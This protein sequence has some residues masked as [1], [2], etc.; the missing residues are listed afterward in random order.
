MPRRT[1]QHGVGVLVMYVVVAVA[2]SMWAPGQMRPVFD[3][4]GSHPGDYHWVNPPKEF[5]EGNQVPDGGE[6]GVAFDPEGSRDA[7]ASTQD[8]QALATIQRGSVPPHPPD[9]S[10]V[11]KLRPL[12]SSEFGPLPEGL[13]AESNVYE[14]TVEY[15]P[16]RRRTTAFTKPG[17]V[18]LTSAGPADVLLYSPDGKRW[19]REEASPITE[20]DGVTGVATGPGYY[21]AASRGDPRS[22]ATTRVPTGLYVALAVVPLAL[23]L[24]LLRRKVEHPR[25]KGTASS[26]PRRPADRRPQKK[27]KSARRPK[28]RRR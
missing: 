26:S 6:A 9:T 20:G 7:G 12:D 24:L 15:L 21:L 14:V 1:L 22:P 11:L 25:R 2:T 3:G 10:A 17:T 19:R 18:A 27:R 13:R 23:G 8:S 28:G 5:A 16:S 4:F